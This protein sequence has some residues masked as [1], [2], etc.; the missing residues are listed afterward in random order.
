MADKKRNGKDEYQAL[1]GYEHVNWVDSIRAGLTP[2]N[3][4]TNPET[5]AVEN[6]RREFLKERIKVRQ[7]EAAEQQERQAEEMKRKLDRK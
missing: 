4:R 1:D 2:D 5:G 6:P 3:L 7:Q